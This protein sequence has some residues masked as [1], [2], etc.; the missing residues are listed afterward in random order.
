MNRS[1]HKTTALPFPQPAR[2]TA[3]VLGALLLLAGGVPLA[4]RLVAHLRVWTAGAPVPG[5]AWLLPFAAGV[6]ALLLLLRRRGDT[7]GEAGPQE[8]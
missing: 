4:E 6:L 2:L 8:G 3:V 1:T 7:A 5:L